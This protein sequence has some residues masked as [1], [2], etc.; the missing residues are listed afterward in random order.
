MQRLA[1]ALNLVAPMKLHCSPCLC[2]MCCEA[3]SRRWSLLL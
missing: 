3:F 1:Y 2:S